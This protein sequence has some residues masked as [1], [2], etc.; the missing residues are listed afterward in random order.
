MPTWVTPAA[1]NCSSRP[2][3]W[4][5]TVSELTA[6]FIRDQPTVRIEVSIERYIGAGL[7]PVSAALATCLL[8]CCRIAADDARELPLGKLAVHRRHRD[9]TG[10]SGG[11]DQLVSGDKPGLV[12]ALQR[13]GSTT[14]R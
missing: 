11:A 10:R 1:R 2:A 9:V 14:R 7:S 3:L 12:G 8:A 4:S 5:C 6:V 13:S